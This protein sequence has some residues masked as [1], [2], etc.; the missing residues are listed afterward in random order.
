MISLSISMDLAC[1][2]FH[3]ETLLAMARAMHV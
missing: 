1:I 3:L 2:L